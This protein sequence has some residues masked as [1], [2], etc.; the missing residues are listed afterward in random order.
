MGNPLVFFDWEGQFLEV[1]LISEIRLPPLVSRILAIYIVSHLVTHFPSLRNISLIEYFIKLLSRI[2]YLV[3]IGQ[4]SIL[5]FAIAHSKPS[6]E[7]LRTETLMSLIIL[8]FIQIQPNCR[9]IV[10]VI[11][12][13]ETDLWLI[14]IWPY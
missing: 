2:G 10:S 4:S 12:S 8:H 1:S 13:S 11:N 6:S 3:L 5:I 9:H 7:T 14:S